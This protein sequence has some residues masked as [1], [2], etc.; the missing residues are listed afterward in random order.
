MLEWILSFGILPFS[1]AL[2]SLFLSW[3]FEMH[4][5]VSRRL[6]IRY[7][8]DRVFI[9]QPLLK[10]ANFSMV[11]TPNSVDKIMKDFYFPEVKNIDQHYVHLF[12][13]Y[14]LIFWIFFEHLIIVF[15]FLAIVPIFLHQFNLWLLLW[16]FIVLFLTTVNLFFI[17]GPKSTDQANQIP[18]DN[19]LAY[20]RQN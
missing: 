20:F 7:L 9:V 5:K 8:W 2:F 11:L 13:H 15:L 10:K 4:N 3:A 14:A 18:I 17:V 12:W 16:F 1:I 19:I 6:Y